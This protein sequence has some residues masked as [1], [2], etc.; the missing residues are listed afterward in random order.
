MELGR[1]AVAAFHGGVPPFERPTGARVIEAFGSPLVPVDQLE[2]TS[3]VLRMAPGA[4]LPGRRG[5]QSM[6]ARDERGD[7]LVAGQA[8]LWQGAACLAA[9]AV[10][11]EALQIGI[12]ILVH[13][14]QRSR[15]NLGPRGRSAGEHKDPEAMRKAGTRPQASSPAPVHGTPP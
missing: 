12:E 15:R 5:V 9:L 3:G 10:A 7:L 14:G 6:P 13:P 4:V 11:V 1:V 8:A 2:I